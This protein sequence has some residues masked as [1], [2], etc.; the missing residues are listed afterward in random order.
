MSVEGE[1]GEVIKDDDVLALFVRR[2]RRFDD[3]FCR[4]MFE[5]TDFTLKLEVHGNKGK[6]IHSRI[7]DDSF[8]RPTSQ[9]KK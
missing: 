9:K 5:G 8:E 6:V 1:Y 4:N 7:V 2:R 3:D